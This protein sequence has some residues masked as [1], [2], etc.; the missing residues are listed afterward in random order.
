MRKIIISF[1]LLTSFIS[2]DK[3]ELGNLEYAETI[4]G[5]CF[6]EKG[7]SLKNYPYANPDMVTYSVTNDSLNI[8]VG[9]NA[10][11]CSEYSTS[12]C[13]EGDSILINILTT[14]LGMCNCICYY[15]YNFKFSGTGEFYKYHVSGINFDFTGVIKIK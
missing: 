1:L 4:E 8:F 7:S 11:C 9:F 12:A 6:L 3:N 13:V 2:C 5:G 15:T 14:Q 10:A